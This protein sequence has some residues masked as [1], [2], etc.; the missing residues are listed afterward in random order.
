MAGLSPLLQR[1]HSPASFPRPFATPPATPGSRGWP[2]QPIPT[3]RLEGAESSEKLNSSFPSIHCGS[4]AETTPGGGDSNTTRRA[5][6]VSLMVPS[7]AGAPGRQFH[8]SASS[9]VEAVGDSQTGRGR[10]HGQQG[11]LACGAEK[12]APGSCQIH[13][14]QYLSRTDPP[15]QGCTRAGMRKAMTAQEAMG[16]LE[17]RPTAEGNRKD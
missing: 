12:V 11:G 9:L 1:S 13:C 17:A 14:S 3:L 2:P 5:R 8:G 15:S 6:P 4:W 16:S 10:G 7:Q